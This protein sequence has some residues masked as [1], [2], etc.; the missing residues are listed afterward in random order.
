MKDPKTARALAAWFRHHWA[1][2]LPERLHV[3]ES[4]AGGGPR[5]TGSLT[6]LLTSEWPNL[7]EPEKTTRGGRP[8]TG[9]DAQGEPLN[10]DEDGRTLD[11]FRYWLEW[12]LV[13]SRSGRE[14]R[15]AQRLIQWAFMGFDSAALAAITPV[16]VE[17][18]DAYLE[19]ALRT[20]YR[21]CQTEPVRFAICPTCR[22]GTCECG[23][24]SESQQHAEEADLHATGPPA[25][26]SP[27]RHTS[28]TAG[29]DRAVAV[30]AA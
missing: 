13:R 1:A 4:D 26:V 30:M 9:W 12:M 3:H 17:F 16:P 24:K 29:S 27:E 22:R 7:K 5:Q 2:S 18:M 11:R 6:R 21:R 10:V 15:Q 28:A 20:L 8:F 25:T 14:N 23:E 19:R